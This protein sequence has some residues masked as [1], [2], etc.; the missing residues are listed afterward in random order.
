MRGRQSEWGGLFPNLCAAGGDE[1]RSVWGR[2][3]M[4]WAR[5]HACNMANPSTQRR[6]GAYTCLAKRA[7]GVFLNH[8]QGDEPWGAH[9]RPE[10]SPTPA[11]LQLLIAPHPAASA[12]CRP[13]SPDLVSSHQSAPTWMSPSSP[14]G[15]P[16]ECRCTMAAPLWAPATTCSTSA[17]WTCQGGRCCRCEQP[18]P[19]HP[20]S[21]AAPAACPWP[22]L[23]P[24][25]EVASRG[26]SVRTV[27][28]DARP[29]KRCHLTPS[30]L[31]PNQG[32]DAGRSV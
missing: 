29:L 21:Q 15:T 10:V 13:L 25:P 5:L 23:P 4:R 7:P 20:P 19:S 31:C 11:A 9:R 16:S 6:K 24:P 14:K 3:S 26:A 32:A 8:A 30:P 1:W 28:Y 2:C 17:P 18:S 22:L 12:S 27:H